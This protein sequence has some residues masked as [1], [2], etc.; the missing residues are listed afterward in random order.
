[1]KWVYGYLA[2]AVCVIGIIGFCAS[3]AIADDDPVL[4]KAELQTHT[5]D[6][7]K[8]H[9]TGINISVKTADGT[10]EIASC[11]NADDSSTDATQYKDG[12]DHS[13]NLAVQFTGA[14]KTA[15]KGFK[16][17]MSISTH[18]GAGHDTWRF[19]AKVL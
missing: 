1:M 3:P 8:D 18:G 4:L 2:A 7:D 16:V 11:S 10:G 13:V 19:N 17:H 15:C 9:D 5:N 14:K 6:E 12:S